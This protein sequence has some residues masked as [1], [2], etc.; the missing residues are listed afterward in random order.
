MQMKKAEPELNIERLCQLLNISA[1][2]YIEIN[3]LS[4]FLRVLWDI[5][6]IIKYIIA[7]FI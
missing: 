4:E 6:S 2:T 7:P 1:S 3:F 5:E